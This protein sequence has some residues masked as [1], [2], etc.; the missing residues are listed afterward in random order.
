MLR[1]RFSHALV[2]VLAGCGSS[3][4]DDAAVTTDATTLDASSD[5]GEVDAGAC[6][7]TPP[8][9]T[10]PMVDGGVIIEGGDAGALPTPS[11]GDPTGRW[12]IDDATLY[13]PAAAQGQVDPSMSW[14]RGTG[15]ATLEGG[16]YQ[17]STD[18]GFRVESVVGG[19]TRGVVLGGRGRYEVRGTELALTPECT[20]S[21]AAAGSLGAFRFSR[22][23][24]DRGRL[25]I[26][27]SGMAG[28]LNLVFRLQRAQ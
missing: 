18:L 1:P 22:D 9:A 27:V 20:T 8:S 24:P 19:L 12:L 26:E 28:R 21:P 16:A 6:V 11:G 17:L 3:S 5:V 4:S 7:L 15:W 23:A 13:L 14:V 2:L 10:L 25:F